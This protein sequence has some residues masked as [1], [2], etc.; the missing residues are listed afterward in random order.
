MQDSAEWVAV[1][2]EEF[3]SR[4]GC[5]KLA[6]NLY[7]KPQSLWVLM[8]CRHELSHQTSYNTLASALAYIDTM[9]AR[10]SKTR[11]S[12]DFVVNINI[13]RGR[14]HV[15]KLA[16]KVL[17]DAVTGTIVPVEDV[18]VLAGAVLGLLDLLK[19]RGS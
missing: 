11:A 10:A 7:A 13:E 6:L 12:S 17:A 14:R 5:W 4:N 16:N 2:T 1:G 3:V 18:A 8:D 9:D 15:E 19:E